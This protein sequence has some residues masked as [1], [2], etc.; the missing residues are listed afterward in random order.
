MTE[1]EAFTKLIASLEEASSCANQIAR[2]RPDQQR[3][4]EQIARLIS[5]AKDQC[6]DF[7]MRGVH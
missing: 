3:G 7:A 4:W 2:F 1:H 6:F 5:A